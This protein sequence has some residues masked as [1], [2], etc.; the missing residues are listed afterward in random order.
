[1]G[2]RKK[3]KEKKRRRRRRSKRRKKDNKTRMK[4]FVA[5]TGEKVQSHERKGQKQNARLI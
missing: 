4:E 5:H 1:M 3:K 2:K